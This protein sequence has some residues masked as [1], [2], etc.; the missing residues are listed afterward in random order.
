[1]DN[2]LEILIKNLV[3]P[4]LNN[5]WKSRSKIFIR[6]RSEKDIKLD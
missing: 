1:M 4:Q 2:E 3:S 6:V 5:K